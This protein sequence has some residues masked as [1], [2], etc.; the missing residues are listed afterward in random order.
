MGDNLAS[1][2]DVEEATHGVKVKCRGRISCHSILYSRTTMV[3]QF[4]EGITGK[5]IGSANDSK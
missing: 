5:I 3:L 2:M 4:T 1:N